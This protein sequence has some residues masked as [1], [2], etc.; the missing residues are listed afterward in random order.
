MRASPANNDSLNH[1]SADATRLPRA[2]VDAVF[3]LE[4]SPHPLRIHIIGDRGP[5]QPNRMLQNLSQSEPKPLQ[6]RSCK[7]PGVA[8]WPKT[9]PKQALIGINVSHPGQE[10][11]VQQCRFDREPSPPEERHKGVGFDPQR[12]CPRSA[13]AFIP[14]QIAKFEA[15]K[16]ARIDKPKL[17]T[18]GKSQARMGVG[19][20]RGIGRRHK[21]S[22][23]HAKMN[24]PLGIRPLGVGRMRP[25]SATCRAKIAH[26]ML[27]GALHAQDDPAFKP[28]QLPARR[29]F[30][31]LPVGS[32]PGLEN[33]VAAHARIHSAGNRLH[34]GKFR[35][36]FILV[37][38]SASIHPSAHPP[39][40][41]PVILSDPERN[42]GESK[43]LLL[44][45][46]RK[47]W[48]TNQPEPAVIPTCARPRP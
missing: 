14:S 13:K 33:P 3:Q 39:A 36:P 11:L 7:P 22:P 34:L 40:P 46:W 4:K 38:R 29:S 6:L 17:T 15:S 8:A 24:N 20:N 37:N 9:R 35:H 19:S 18:A 48:E 12:L 44:D 42:D 1:R 10:R 21:Q 30:E 27:P 5:S 31:R 26:N 25:L 45:L 41:H 28:L 32:E 2:L 16:P 43:D 23:R 47:G